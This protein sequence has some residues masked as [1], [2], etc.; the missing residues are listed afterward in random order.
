MIWYDC[1]LIKILTLTSILFSGNW[2]PPWIWQSTQNW[3]LG[4]FKQN[5]TYQAGRGQWAVYYTSPQSFI[6]CFLI[7]WFNNFGYY[8]WILIGWFIKLSVQMFKP[9]IVICS[10]GNFVY[11]WG[12]TQIYRP[13]SYPFRSL[14]IYISWKDSFK[15]L[16]TELKIA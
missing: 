3:M 5:K 16:C 4:G 10:R 11:H 1:M 6:K 8:Y 2:G 14:E 7:H 12:C 13:L 15:K 9:L